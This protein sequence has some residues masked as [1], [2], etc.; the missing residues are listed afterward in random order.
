V[1][2]SSTYSTRFVFHGSLPGLRIGTKPMPSCIASGAP[3]RNP[4][5]SIA[6]TQSTLPKSIAARRRI[7]SFI[8]AG[9]ASSGVMSLNRMPGFG[10]S[11]TSRRCLLRSICE[12]AGSC[13]A[14]RCATA[15]AD[16]RGRRV[17]WGPRPQTAGRG[18]TFRRKLPTHP[19]VCSRRPDYIR[20]GAGMPSSE[21]PVARSLRAASTSS[22][23]ASRTAGSAP[24][25][26][27]SRR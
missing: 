13:G 21:S 22:R 16:R 5:D 27:W 24:S 12:G 18:G 9:C 15:A 26:W 8:A 11:G 7:V 4:R 19:A 14:G 23:R 10:K 2:Y 1:P 6:A 25:T 17:A 3:N 20:S